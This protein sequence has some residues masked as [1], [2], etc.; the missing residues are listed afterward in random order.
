M[1]EEEI[2]GCSMIDIMDQTREDECEL[3][4]WIEEVLDGMFVVEIVAAMHDRECMIEVMEWI[5]TFVVMMMEQ[6][7]EYS[8]LFNWEGVLLQ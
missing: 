2:G 6:P 1:N 4:E 5:V 8:E 3:V 7:D